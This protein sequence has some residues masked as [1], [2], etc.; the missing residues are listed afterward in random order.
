MNCN[1]FP[2]Y[3]K[4]QK[5]IEEGF[6]I[7]EPSLYQ[8]FK[9]IWEYELIGEPQ[10]KLREITN[11]IYYELYF[12]VQWLVYVDNY[13]ESC[14]RTC[15]NK[16]EIER[17]KQK[18]LPNCPLICSNEKSLEIIKLFE[19]K[20]PTCSAES[21][22]WLG[23]GVCNSGDLIYEVLE[24]IKQGERKLIRVPLNA[25]NQYYLNLGIPQEQ[26]TKLLQTRTIK[27]KSELCCRY[28]SVNSPLIRILSMTQTSVTFEYQLNN[29]EGTIT[30]KLN[31]QVQSSNQSSGT[32]TF[33]GLS[34]SQ[35]YKLEVTVRNCAGSVS[36]EREFDTP[37]Y[38]LK[39]ILDNNLQGNL[40]LLNGLQVGDNVINT[41]CSQIIVGF[42]GINILHKITGF[43]VNGQERINDV[44][45]NQI[46]NGSNVG[47]SYIFPCF[48]KD[49]IVE[50]KG[51][52]LLTCSDINVNMTGNTITISV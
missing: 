32:I 23:E 7:L 9:D 41:H 25:N 28:E 18:F 36:I 37:P 51:E 29:P 22:R 21:Y 1:R 4:Y 30:F 24:I 34:I 47:G 13:L 49:A 5:L 35:N 12:L 19:S 31:N 17:I 16:E 52:R 44:V 8:Y 14:N 39:I 50:I 26:V 33:S 15:L 6:K 11:N 43:L 20:I 46:I 2:I 38:I 27:E 3:T 45:F 10:D 40:Q 42:Q 48:D